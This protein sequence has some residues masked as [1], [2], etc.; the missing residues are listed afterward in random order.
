MG[1][2]QACRLGGRYIFITQGS[3]VQSHFHETRRQQQV[4]LHKIRELEVAKKDHIYKIK[5]RKPFIQKEKKGGG[6]EEKQ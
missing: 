2:V 6:G 5:R 3:Q 1:K 4:F